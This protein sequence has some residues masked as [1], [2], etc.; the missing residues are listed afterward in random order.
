MTLGHVFETNAMEQGS[1]VVFQF[2]QVAHRDFINPQRPNDRPAALTFHSGYPD[3]H[4]N[5]GTYHQNRTVNFTS[6]TNHFVKLTENAQ[7]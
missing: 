7:S 1:L 5:A 4:Q 3:E 6:K 2:T